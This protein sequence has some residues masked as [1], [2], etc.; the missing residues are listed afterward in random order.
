MVE[1][2]TKLSDNT[3]GH[4]TYITS[5]GR[6]LDIFSTMPEKEVA[7]IQTKYWESYDENYHPKSNSSPIEHKSKIKTKHHQEK[8]QYHK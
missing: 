7:A 3:I 5:D 6:R 1:K 2:N 4:I 8:P